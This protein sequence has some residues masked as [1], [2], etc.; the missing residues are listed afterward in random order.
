M[1]GQGGGSGVGREAGVE[2]RRGNLKSIYP[3]DKY[4]VQTSIAY[5]AR[6]RKLKVFAFP[7]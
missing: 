2:M 3:K 1:V 5:D 6:N 4:T 7:F